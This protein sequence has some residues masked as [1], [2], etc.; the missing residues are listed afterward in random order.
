[1]PSV[2]PYQDTSDYVVWLTLRSGLSK[3]D[4]HIACSCWDLI[5]TLNQGE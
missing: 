2:P 4:A 1:L 3:H 5:A